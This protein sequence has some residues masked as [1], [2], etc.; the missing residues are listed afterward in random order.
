MEDKFSKI[1]SVKF[2]NYKCFEDFTLDCRKPDGKPYQW[3]VLL[4]DNNTGKTNILRAIA[5]LAPETLVF[6][7]FTF[8]YVPKSYWVGPEDDVFK[9]SS[10][11]CSEILS[12]SVNAW[13]YGGGWPPAQSYVSSDKFEYNLLK[14]LNILGY[15]V[16]RYPSSTNL[17]QNDC[18]DCETLFNTSKRLT[19]IE[20]W[21]MQ[22]D[23]AGKS[24]QKRAEKQLE[25]I[26]EI[27]CGKVFPEI[28]DFKF[29][30]SEDTLKNYVLFQTKD[31]WFRYT[32]LGFGYQSTLAWVVDLCRRM[33]ELYPESEDPLKEGAVVLVD[34]IDLHLHPK[35][36]REVI[37]D[38]S[39]YFPNIQFIVT[40]HSP[41]VVQSMSDVNLYTLSRP[42]GKDKV[43]VTRSERRN[44]SGW[45]VE[46]IMRETMGLGEDVHSNIYNKQRQLFDDALDAEDKAKAKEAY[47]VLDK[48]LHPNNPIRRMLRLQFQSI[49]SDD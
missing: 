3:T 48:I 24:K 9:V 11:I 32:D 45:T 46:E 17:S 20:E 16:T 4:G 2:E 43:I 23:Y 35:W 36:Q 42:E 30:S 14:E 12:I 31:G 8:G 40:T 28:T 6:D 33:F 41:A 38:L 26:K 5:G 13:G 39:T 37:G 21:L 10:L 1:L 25:K 29:I 18:E 22:L 49:D 27:L 7:T 47:E 15:G 19:N 44:F 34:E